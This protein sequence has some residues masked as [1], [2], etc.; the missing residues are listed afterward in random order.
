MRIDKSF[1]LRQIAGDYVI[2]PTGSTTLQFNGMIT[3]NEQGA[4]LWE[5]LSRGASLDEI[6][7]AMLDE[8]DVDR[9][10]AFDDVMEFLQILRK[11]K[12]LRED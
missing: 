8:Y 10:T 4:F 11:S 7:E 9:N 12:L 6:V 5:R 2:L 3:V 1:V